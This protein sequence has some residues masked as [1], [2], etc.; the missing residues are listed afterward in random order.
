MLRIV[1]LSC[2]FSMN[3]SSRTQFAFDEGI[4]T[5]ELAHVTQRRCEEDELSLGDED[6]DVDDKKKTMDM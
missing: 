3:H 4:Y 2:P 6:S 5:Q 1:V